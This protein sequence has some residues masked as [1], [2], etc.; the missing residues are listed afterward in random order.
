MIKELK[1]FHK[2]LG[3]IFI[4]SGIILYPTPIPR[5]TLLIVLGFVWII[6]KKRTLHFFKEIL[7]KKMFKFLKINKIIKKT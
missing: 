1:N 6:G 4:F 3:I 7:S 5:T 2:V